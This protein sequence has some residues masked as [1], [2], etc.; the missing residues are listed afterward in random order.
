MMLLRKVL[1]L[2][3]T[4]CRVWSS[5]EWSVPQK[6]WIKGALLS[7]NWS[8][9]HVRLSN[10]DCDLPISSTLTIFPKPCRYS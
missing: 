3:S 9:S 5:G 1:S 10:D 2:S 7:P 6:R 4:W 8:K